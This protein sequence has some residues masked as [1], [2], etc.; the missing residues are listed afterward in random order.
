MR[1]LLVNPPLAF[2]GWEHLTPG[3]AASA[4]AAG[5]DLQVFARSV[6]T[7]PLGLLSIR[8]VL[9]RAGHPTDILDLQTHPLTRAA[10]LRELEERAPQ[11]VGVTALT[12]GYPPALQ[13]VEAVK[14]WRRAASTVLGGPHVTFRD[15]EALEHPDVDFVV[16]HEGELTLLELV[17]ALAAREPALERIRGLSFASIDPA[18]GRRAVVRNPTR[19][20]IRDLDQLPIPDRADLLRGGYGRAGVLATSRGCPGRC[21]FC[22]ASAMSGGRFRARSPEGVVQEMAYLHGELGIPNLEI[23]DD[24]MTAEPGRVLRICRLLR[25]RLPAVRWSCMSRVDA[26]SAAELDEMARAGCARIHFGLESG[27]PEVLPT[28]GK[29]IELAQLRQAVGWAAQAGM[30]VTCSFIVGHHQDTAESIDRTLDLVGELR[31]RHGIESPSGIN[32]P[33]P[34]TPLYEHRERYG[35]SIVGESWGEFRFDNCVIR[36]R[37]LATEEIQFHFHRAQARTAGTNEAG[38]RILDRLGLA[39]P[40]CDPHTLEAL[41]VP[42]LALTHQMSRGAPVGAFL[43][44]QPQR[45][46]ELHVAPRDSG[47]AFLGKEEG[48]EQ[49][50]QAIRS[51]GG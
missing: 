34:G 42:W 18:T 44:E 40:S 14:C 26:V 33:F 4:G 36:T 41:L 16:R 32:T 12:Q 31:S 8:E 24:T 21:V 51:S 17:E 3:A 29:E 11:L 30:H 27:D 28:I 22:S 2:Q 45:H 20:L 5:G 25:E 6:R 49:R 39:A 1:V 23:V 43:P 9:R 47:T 15:R 38:R 46:A 10:F 48:S 19:P 7:I 35:V 37:H 13:I 50:Q